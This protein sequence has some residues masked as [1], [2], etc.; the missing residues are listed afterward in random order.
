MTNRSAF[1][2]K[3]KKLKSVETFHKHEI[4][5]LACRTTINLRADFILLG[6]E[7]CSRCVYYTIVNYDFP[8]T[9]KNMKETISLPY[10]FLL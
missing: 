4:S 10:R 2:M 7:N 9:K 3:R 1:T 8:R 6:N 5:N